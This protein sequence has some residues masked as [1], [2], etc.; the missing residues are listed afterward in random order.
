MRTFK[1]V[2]LTALFIAL[3]AIG[4]LY[5][6]MRASLPVEDGE[7]RLPGLNAQVTV[8]SDE[9]GV[10]AI[11]AENR[12][13]ALQVL[14]FLHARD[15]LFQME[16]MRRKSAGRLA[17]LFGS[18]AVAS[19][20]KQRAYQLSKTAQKIVQDLPAEQRRLL[21]AY[22][23]GVNAYLA[24]TRI[25]PPEFLLLRHQSELWREEDTLLVVL[26][27]FQI[28]NG[29]EQ[30][31][32]MFT[33]MEK[34]LPKDLL[35]FL[36]PDTDSYT[37]TLVGGE[38]PRRFNPS[39]SS[40]VFAGLPE[41]DAVLTQ[42]GVDAQN[43]VLGSNNWVVAGSKTVDGRTLVANDMHLGLGVPNIWYR[44][45]MAYPNRQVYGVSLPGVPGI[46][47]GGNDDI[48]WGFTNVT[49]DLLDLVSLDVNPDNPDEY[50]TA[51]GWL[52]FGKHTETIQIKDAPAIEITV[53]DTLWGPV[54]EQSLLGKPVVIKWTA[55][56]PH[57]VDLGLLGMDDAHSVQQAMAVLNRIGAPPQN[58]VIADR[59]GHIGW[60]YMGRFPQR[61]GFDGLASRSWANG[62]LAWQQFL[63]PD[64][65]PRLIDPPEG[66]IVTAN[67]R[68]LGRNYPHAI[69]HNWAL[70]YRAFRIAELLRE[71]NHLSEPD[72][73]AIQLDTR[74][75]VYDF[76]RQ[77]ALDELQAISDKDD[78]LQTIEQTL[79]AWDGHMSTDSIG[80]ALLAEFRG[81]LANEVFA[82]IVAACQFYDA[83]FRY[84]WREMETPL[85]LLLVQRPARL[86]RA[87]YRD[88]WPRMIVASLRQSAH[89]LQQEYPHKH[90]ANLRWAE[91]H[92]ITL[93]HPFSKVAPLLGELLDMPRFQSD[94]CAG[95]C[96]KVMDTAHGAS[97]RLVLSPLHP[98]D[99]IFHMPGGQS[100][101]PFSAHYRDQ[102]PYWQ[103]GIASPMQTNIVAHS[104]SFLPRQR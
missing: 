58:V 9:L 75:A 86:L 14:G 36:T 49:A 92:P 41:P 96:V 35:V 47:V 100:G 65:L 30:D 27:M 104:L 24:Q 23:A 67:N 45:D 5:L 18:V 88:D 21:Q 94:G 61:V 28:L 77:L 74:N 72:L 66:F 90:L 52:E 103:A 97:E 40:Q 22:V 13:D 34:A 26:G 76:Y 70:G 2:S 11:S 3:T 83:D 78:E 50:R 17:E 63:A 4:I 101:H 43:L 7:L 19:D 16:L 93:H 54:S 53:R 12:A 95:L 39:V 82:K 8:N 91:T 71:Q 55:L 32:R 29:Y 51:N 84:A 33:V 60:T 99:A 25:L 37:T 31:E 79:Q 80:A 48:A 38:K 59:A 1:L 42:A 64:A 57:G 87:Q 69:A 15:R 102:Q 10:P 68:T 89:Q 44:A 98:E 6:L 85:R 81:Q 62:D 73:L 46:I 56:Q 20:R